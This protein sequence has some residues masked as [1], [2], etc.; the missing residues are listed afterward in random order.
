MVRRR[1]VN[2]ISSG[3]L[4]KSSSHDDDKS[5]NKI[6]TSKGSDEFLLD[7]RR[8]ETGEDIIVLKSGTEI[9]DIPLSTIREK[10][11]SLYE[12]RNVR[13]SQLPEDHKEKFK[14]LTT[15]MQ[16]L[17]NTSSY[18][19]L[20]SLIDEVFSKGKNIILPGTINA[21]LNGC[22]V[23][24]N[25]TPFACSPICSGSTQ[26]V[27][28]GDGWSMCDKYTILFD[29]KDNLFTIM[30]KPSNK[31]E[32][33]IYISSNDKFTG[34]SNHEKDK[35]S[36]K[37]IKR[38]KIISYDQTGKNTTDISDDFVPLENIKT[39]IDKMGG[40]SGNN[41]STGENLGGWYIFFWVVLAIIILLALALLIYFIVI[42]S[43]KKNKTERKST[44]L[45]S[46]HRSRSR[47]PSS[48]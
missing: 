35:L 39:K 4:L 30:N 31:E 17:R 19:E 34:F 15:I 41:G 47:I 24:T 37:G 29:A 32:A 40:T 2:T 20:I 11:V 26:P 9:I 46:S 12:V 5:N 23:H 21:Y 28:M 8:D 38:V 33:Y 10:L 14:N 42:S 22:K 43:R 48:A 3:K 27:D 6:Y 25:F 44:R 1:H 7:K 13:I 18:N 36:E 16:G 45:N